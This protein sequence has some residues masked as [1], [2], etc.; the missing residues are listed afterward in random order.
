MNRKKN[1]LMASACIVLGMALAGPAA[2]A[3]ETFLRAFPSTHHVTVDGVPVS[4][5]AYT[6]NGSN[7]VKLRDIAA[8]VDFSVTWDS[9][10]RTVEIDTGADY[11]DAEQP[12][13]TVTAPNS[14]MDT[15]LDSVRE[16]IV[17][18]TNELREE[19]GLPALA[20]DGDLMA[21]AQVRA[22]EAAANLAYRHT[23]PDG[24]D[25][26]TV[27]LHTGTLLLGENM[28]MKDLAG[29]EV[30]DLAEIQVASWSCSPGHC[31]N[32]LNT[33]YHATGVGIA[34][35]KYGMYYVVQLFA[36]GDYAVTG[37]DGPILP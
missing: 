12:E 36:G 19:N 37:I 28:G 1:I 17:E 24:S 13:T 32:M 8:L 5:E 6:I 30:R 14:G 20:M 26:D 27:L 31:R 9:D 35:D 25:N 2:H 11:A 29:S 21:A 15:G 16:E 3:A 10:T 4:V 34:R 7:C 18:L 33:I 22:E 23:R